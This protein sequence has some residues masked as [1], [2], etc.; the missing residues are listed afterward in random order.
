MPIVKSKELIRALERLGFSRHHKSRGSHIV[1][2]HSDGRR[3]VVPVHSGKDLP[4]GTLFGIIKDL[5]I[6]KEDFIKIL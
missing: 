4:K 5:N 2:A 6:S 1:M 3:V